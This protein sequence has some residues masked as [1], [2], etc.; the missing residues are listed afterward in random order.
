MNQPIRDN[1]GV[2][3]RQGFNRRKIG[4]KPAWEQQHFVAAEPLRQ[5]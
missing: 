1:G 4:L 5:L 2:P 3:V